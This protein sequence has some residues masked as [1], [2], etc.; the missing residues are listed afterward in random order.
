M[1]L[2]FRTRSNQSTVSIMASIKRNLLILQDQP[3][4]ADFHKALTAHNWKIHLTRNIDEALD[5][6]TRNKFLVGFCLIEDQH[7]GKFWQKLRKLCDRSPKI[8]WIMGLSKASLNNISIHSSDNLLFND[9]CIA[10]YCFDYVLLPI[11]IEHLSFLLDHAYGMA[12]L[13]HSCCREFTDLLSF[14]G[15][16][17]ASPV[18]RKLYKQIE[19]ASR[20]DLSV[21]IQGETGTGKEL[22][23][24]AIHKR[25]RRHARPLV[26]INCGAFPPELIQGELFGWEKGAFTGAHNRR[27]GRIET[28]QGGV[29]FLDEVGDLPLSQQVNLLRFLE[30]R[31]IERLGGTEKIPIDVRIISATH[32]NL[33]QA[34]QTGKF[35]EDLYYRLKVLHLETPPLRSRGTDIELLAWF[36]FT[37]FSK[38]TSR[39]PKGFNTEALC[40]LQKYDW[41]GNIR[42][43]QNCIRHAVIMS[44]N[45]LLTP[46][47]LGL[48]KRHK[49]RTIKTLEEARAE[50]DREAIMNSIQSARYNMSR[51]A[52]I[53]NIS[54]VSLYR[55]IEK[56]GI[57]IPNPQHQ[58]S[59]LCLVNN[60]YSTAPPDCS[61]LIMPT[62]R[63]G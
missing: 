31:S 43:L 56:Y 16:I 4:A 37:E 26:A 48:D 29:L 49:E 58:P 19:K 54:R 21:L 28:A 6:L 47:D 52:E 23:A 53:L 11:D 51:A 9:Y 15:I 24:D 35:R 8:N 38:N 63:N 41:P 2:E 5:L 25:S 60:T 45:H 20:E 34:V 1:D 18:M 42:E 14:E 30:E 13:A 33:F 46:A 40:L 59:T 62:T 10:D 61:H 3:L 17:G 36:F 55:M 44:E 22:I 39:K 27:I 57:S 32:V 50:A 7:D 12:E